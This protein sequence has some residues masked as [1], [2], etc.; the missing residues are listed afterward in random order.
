VLGLIVNGE[1]ETNA[2][3]NNTSIKGLNRIDKNTLRWTMLE[4]G[5]P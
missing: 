5:E 3:Q 1:D 2:F 4:G